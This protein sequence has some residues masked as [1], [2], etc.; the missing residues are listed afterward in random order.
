MS[1]TMP[2]QTP[3]NQALQMALN[4]L[5]SPYTA[6][7]YEPLVNA[8]VAPMAKANIQGNAALGGLENSFNAAGGGQGMLPGLLAKI[9]GALTGNNVAAYDQQRQ[10]VAQQLASMGVPATALP[11]VTDTPEAA[12]A[13]IAQIQSVLG[14]MNGAG[15]QPSVLGSLAGGR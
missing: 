8:L 10:Q 6:A 13:K 15:A 3:T 4:G 12:A 7:S 11:E 1:P 2:Q 14:A 5:Q 9:G